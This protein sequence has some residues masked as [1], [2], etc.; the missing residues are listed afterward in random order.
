MVLFLII[1]ELEFQKKIILMIV[2]FATNDKIKN[3]FDFPLEN[4]DVQL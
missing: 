2:C 1:K 3:C 4:Q